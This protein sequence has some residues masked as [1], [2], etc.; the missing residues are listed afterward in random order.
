MKIISLSSWYLSRQCAVEARKEFLKLDSQTPVIFWPVRP[1]HF[2]SHLTQSHQGFHWQLLLH[3]YCFN[4]VS[5]LQTRH[6]HVTLSEWYCSSGCSLRSSLCDCIKA[7][8]AFCCQ[9]SGGTV[10]VLSYRL[11]SWDVG[12]SLL[13]VWRR[14]I[15]SYR[16]I[17]MILFTCT[18]T[19]DI[20]LFRV[21][22]VQRIRGLFFGIDALYKLM[23][24][25]LSYFYLLRAGFSMHKLTHWLANWWLAPPPS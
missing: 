13:P 8:Y 7:T 12:P 17:C 4:V 14:G 5:Q 18:F 2:I 25:L 15:L 21:L 9:S 16:D 3:L 24:Y 20:S 22:T 1:E 23:F 6:D 19:E 11:S 10:V